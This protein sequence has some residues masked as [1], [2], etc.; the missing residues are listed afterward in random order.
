MSQLQFSMELYT[1][2]KNIMISKIENENI[3]GTYM[4]DNKKRKMLVSF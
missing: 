2:E 3:F 1:E 4:Y